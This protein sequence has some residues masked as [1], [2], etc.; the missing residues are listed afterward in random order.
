[1]L[2]IFPLSKATKQNSLFIS[3]HGKALAMRKNIAKLF[4]EA[5]A[6]GVLSSQVLVTGVISRVRH[7]AAQILY[8]LRGWVG[9]KVTSPSP[10]PLPDIV[11]QIRNPFPA[12]VS[13]RR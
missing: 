12:A 7:T 9:P 2:L 8:S 4:L 1:M 6:F 5:I 13:T 10:K 3:P 11:N